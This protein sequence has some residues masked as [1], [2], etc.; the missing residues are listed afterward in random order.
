MIKI[1]YLQTT[2]CTVLLCYIVNVYSLTRICIFY[3]SGR[4][5]LFLM[6]FKHIEASV[7]FFIFFTV[8]AVDLDN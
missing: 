8:L 1:V 3:K 5:W 6:L 4:I 7:I 2:P